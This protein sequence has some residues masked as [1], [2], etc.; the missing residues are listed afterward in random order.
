MTIRRSPRR[1]P[2]RGAGRPWAETPWTHSAVFAVAALAVIA[3]MLAHHGDGGGG[4]PAGASSGQAVVA[5]GGGNV[6][7]AVDLV[8]TAVSTETTT[9]TPI[10]PTPRPTASAEP[11]PP[12]LSEG[13]QIRGVVLDTG[14][15]PIAGA[16]VRVRTKI[17]E[18]DAEGRFT[19]T[20]R[21]GA[22]R[23]TVSASGY[24][25]R[26]VTITKR[27]SVALERFVVKGVY[28]NGT[29]AGDKDIVD[30][31][32]DLIDTTELNAIVVDFKDGV[33]F[34]D[35]QVD[36]FRDAGAVRPTYDAE[37]LI[38]KLHDH[39]I[40]V[41][42]RQVVFKDPLVAEAHPDMAIQD[43]ETGGLWRGWAGEA[44]VNPLATG[45]YQPNVDLAAEAARLG[46]DEIQYD[47][48]RFP[49]GDLS[50]ADLG[51][52]YDSMDNRIGALT[53]ILSMT[54]EALRPLGAKLSADLFG[55]MLLVDDDQGIGQRLPDLVAVVDYASPMV[56]PSH[57]PTGSV[58]VDGAPNDFPFET[59]EISLSL[60]MER[61]PGAEL[62]IRPW[63]QDFSLP[64]MTEYTASD[65]R[66]QI[67]AAE[68][69]GSSGWLM[70][71]VNASYEDGAYDP[72][73]D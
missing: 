36:F 3:T 20:Y 14:G 28:L 44:W 6:P 33:V 58:A 46:F 19:L 72:S 53:T 18:T 70:W 61:I 73:D 59:V 10:P 40:Y 5:S 21:S 41:I 60:G 38:D 71:N 16:V 30:A 8:P 25:D 29:A 9:A 26:S 66:A 15:D 24:A 64:E 57:F 55:W 4:S 52:R 1:S 2:R 63:L 31:M 45:L 47:Y 69:V 49:D 50:G 22:D 27:P 48:I 68:S 65:V 11:T 51:K 67:Q 39:D 17:V 32:I 54:R 42:G 43:E 35:S 13:D 56:Y 34:Y 7:T 23:M 62:K 12:P 37:K